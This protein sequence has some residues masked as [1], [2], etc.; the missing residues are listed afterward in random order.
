MMICRHEEPFTMYTSL[1]DNGELNDA[2]L[3]LMAHLRLATC[4]LRVGE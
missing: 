3:V 2:L 4:T 1:K